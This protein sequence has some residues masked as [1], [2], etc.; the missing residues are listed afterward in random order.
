[1]GNEMNGRIIN[2][3]SIRLGI[4]GA[5]NLGSEIALVALCA[6][7]S[8]TLYDNSGEKLTDAYRYIEYQLAS[9]GRQIRLR[10]LKLSEEIEALTGAGVIVEVIP[11]DLEQIRNLLATLDRICPPPAILVVSTGTFSVTALAAATKNPERVAGMHFINLNAAM[12]VVEVVQAA[13]TQPEIIADLVRL[14]G[15]LEKV[16]IV[17]HDLPGF[18]IN[19]ILQPFY[20]EALRLLGEGAATLNQ[21]DNLMRMG[22]GFPNGPFQLMDLIGIDVNLAVTKSMYERTFGEPRYRPHPIQLRMLQQ[23]TLGRKTKQ[24]FYSYASE[25]TQPEALP[26]AKL[27]GSGQVYLSLGTCCC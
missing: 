23:G 12:P 17:V 19:R 16:P 3:Y 5:G 24:G 7:I 26:P 14:S 15:I 21:I 22:A 2:P 11:E 20:G 27:R 18:I 25:T 6:N 13:Q 4:V 8:V 10:D 9:K 1:M